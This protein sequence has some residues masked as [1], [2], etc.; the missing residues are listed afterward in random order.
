M[1]AELDAAI[2]ARRSVRRF[3]PEPVPPS[4]IADL[5]RA[6]TRAPSAH[7]RQPWRFHIVRDE[8][9]KARLA[10]AMGDRLRADRSRDGDDPDLIRQD[11]ERSSTRINGAPVVIAV[12][13]TLEDMDSYPD[14]RRNQ[15][16]YLMAAQ[17]T[18][19]AAQL[20][21][22]KAQSVGLGACWVCAPLF[23]P[24]TVRAALTLREGWRPQGLILLGWPAEPGRD[25]VRKPLGEIIS[26]MELVL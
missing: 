14:D 2:F 13:L 16:E 7:N 17:S 5:V 22:L 23:C 11:V 25:R 24:E 20:L 9:E 18:A 21:L 26:G 12:C 19:M 6:A 4:L 10:G 1:A 3:Q 8:S 15:A